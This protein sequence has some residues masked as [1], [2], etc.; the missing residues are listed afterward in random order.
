MVV[1]PS[2][3][4]LAMALERPPYRWQDDAARQ[5]ESIPS[6]AADGGWRDHEPPRLKRRVRCHLSNIEFRELDAFPE[7]A[8]AVL[9]RE[10][11][12]DFG[13]PSQDL[14]DLLSLEAAERNNRSESAARLLVRIGAFRGSSLVGWSLARCEAG[15]VLYMV[16][17]GVAVSE[18]RHGVYSG[19]VQRVID[20]ARSDGYV[21]VTSRHVPMNNAAIIAKLKLGFQVSGFE[22]SEVYGPLVRLVYLVSEQRRKLY[23]SRATPIV[24]RE[25]GT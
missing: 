8:F 13:H 11:F 4:L 5:E 24:P 14:A 19:L 1:A 9:S 3:L 10:A 17:S 23:G 7:P 6:L 21:S 15:H 12:R 25:S 20:H 16:N 22:Y 18:R 2:G